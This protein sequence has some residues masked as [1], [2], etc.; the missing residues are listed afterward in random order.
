MLTSFNM[1]YRVRSTQFAA[2]WFAPTGAINELLMALFGASFDSSK[3]HCVL[4]V[5]CLL[6][7]K[8][9]IEKYLLY[10]L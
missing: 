1:D 2:F 8:R 10:F 4:L 5:N 9:K 3:L 7:V 6:N